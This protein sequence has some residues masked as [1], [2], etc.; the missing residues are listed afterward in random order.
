MTSW[1]T[2]E[3]SHFK[4]DQPCTHDASAPIFTHHG[5]KLRAANEAGFKA[6][7]ARADCFIDLANLTRGSLPYPTGSSQFFVSPDSDFPFLQLELLV[8]GHGRLRR[9]YS[10]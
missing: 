7:F 10:A 9:P 4:D 5:V 2:R 1:D 3:D 6:A 8:H